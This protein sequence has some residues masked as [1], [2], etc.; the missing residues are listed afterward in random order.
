MEAYELVRARLDALLQQQGA[1]IDGTY[2]CP[3]H[4]DFSGPCACRKPG[5]ELYRQ[6]AADLELDLSRS[7]FV[8]D[9]WRDIAPALA[10]GGRGILV[11]SPATPSEDRVD[12]S[13]DGEIA[14]TLAEAVRSLL[15]TS[16]TAA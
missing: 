6:A 13:R 2:Y 8:G 10:L 11:P 3:H 4:P 16:P 14:T 9:R 15:G 12:A 7:V 5:V 1:R